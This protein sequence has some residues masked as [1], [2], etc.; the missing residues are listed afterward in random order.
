MKK[1]IWS[2][3]VNHELIREKVLVMGVS[4]KPDTPGF[5]NTA[6]ACIMDSYK[7]YHKVPIEQLSLT[8]EDYNKF[9]CE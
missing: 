9:F 8:A 6:Y 4:I 7:M 2:H 5:D 1:M 3:L